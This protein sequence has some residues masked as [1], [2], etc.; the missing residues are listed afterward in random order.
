MASCQSGHDPGRRSARRSGRFTFAQHPQLARSFSVKLEH[1]SLESQRYAVSM[2]RRADDFGNDSAIDIVNPEDDTSAEAIAAWIADLERD[3]DW[4]DLG[5]TAA[6]LI[7][8][9]RAVTG[10]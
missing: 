4:I 7:A 8:E 10:S 1:C 2:P 3:D 9:D 5:S 6:D